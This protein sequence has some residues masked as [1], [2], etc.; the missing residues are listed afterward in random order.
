MSTKESK[1][2]ETVAKENTTISFI[3]TSTVAFLIMKIPKTV[4]TT[5]VLKTNQQ[6]DLGRA[7]MFDPQKIMNI[8]DFVFPMNSTIQF[9]IFLKF[10]MSFKIVFPRM[11]KKKS[12]I[13]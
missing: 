10:N 9:Q 7:F 13:Q 2:S 8:T 5:I 3:L 4:S 1:I 6:S 12:P 11:F